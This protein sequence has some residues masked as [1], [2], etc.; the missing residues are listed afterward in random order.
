MMRLIHFLGYETTYRVSMLECVEEN[1][2][3]PLV[4][5]LDLFALHVGFT[6]V[7]E[8]A[9]EAR[10]R[11]LPRDALGDEL[12]ALHYESEVRDRQGSRAFGHDMTRESDA[13]AHLQSLPDKL[14]TFTGFSC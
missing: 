14:H 6:G 2:V 9:A 4:K 10:G 8:L 5:L 13:A 1:L 7:A 11:E 3:A 12:D